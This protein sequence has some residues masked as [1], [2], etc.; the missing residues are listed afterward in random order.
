MPAIGSVRRGTASAIGTSSAAGERERVQ[1]EH[2]HQHQRRARPG[3]GQVEAID[4]ADP[5]AVEHEAEA[6]VEAGE[7]EERQQRRIVQADI[8]Q[9]RRVGRGIL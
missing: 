5:L 8:D 4:G 1:Q 2:Q 6:D 3:T 9:L 7:E